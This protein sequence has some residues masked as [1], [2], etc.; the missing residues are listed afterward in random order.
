MVEVFDNTAAE[1]CEPQG[2]QAQRTSL[3]GSFL[4]QISIVFS[5]SCYLRFVMVV[6][7]T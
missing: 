2:F 5:N 4:Y 6:L 1:I 7:K 3:I